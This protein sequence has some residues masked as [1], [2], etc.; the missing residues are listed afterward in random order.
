[1]T[2]PETPRTD[3]DRDEAEETSAFEI[4]L[5]PEEQ[6]SAEAADEATG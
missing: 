5:E 6:G 4:D 1:M 3:D 2:D